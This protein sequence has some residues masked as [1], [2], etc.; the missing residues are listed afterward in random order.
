M[1]W[2]V[3]FLS[4]VLEAVWATAL[5]RSDGFTN[6]APSAVFLV[7]LAASMT[8]LAY[9]ARSI[10]IGIAYAIWAGT[11]AA[12][13]AGWAIVTGE[14][15]ASL[16]KV[17]LL[18]GVIFCVVGLKLAKSSPPPSAPARSDEPR[19]GADVVPVA[20]Q[21]ERNG[22]VDVASAGSPADDSRGVVPSPRAERRKAKQET[23]AELKRAKKEQAAKKAQSGALS[24]AL[25]LGMMMDMFN[26]DPGSGLSRDND[27][28]QRS[29][30]DSKHPRP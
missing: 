4:A 12:L 6:P 16:A 25:G 21:A 24:D 15:S 27:K 17:L 11:G 3:L 18:A 7:A 30:D 14:E 13:T 9:A 2:F 19:S 29:G 22:G 26:S 10:P 28:P 20:A 8:T 5:G 23:K 1:P